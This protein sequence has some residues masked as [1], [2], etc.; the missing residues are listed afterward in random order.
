M[1]AAREYIEAQYGDD[2]VSTTGKTVKEGTEDPG[3]A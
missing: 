2:Y 3:C 1:Q